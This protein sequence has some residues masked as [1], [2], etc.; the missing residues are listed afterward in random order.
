VLLIPVGLN[1][2]R[3]CFTRKASSPK[4]L[5]RPFYF[6]SYFEFFRFPCSSRPSTGRPIKFSLMPTSAAICLLK[7]GDGSSSSTRRCSCTR[8]RP[9]SVYPGPSH[10]FDAFIPLASQ[11]AFQFVDCTD[12]ISQHH[13]NRLSAS[14]AATQSKHGVTHLEPTFLRQSVP[15]TRETSASSRRPLI[16]PAPL[17][18]FRLR[19]RPTFILVLRTDYVIGTT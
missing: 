7:S 19:K 12:Q 15:H 10:F 4:I 13:T 3:R 2:C 6:G 18:R 9:Q 17:D 14:T 8:R 11:C 16:R 1:E 5:T